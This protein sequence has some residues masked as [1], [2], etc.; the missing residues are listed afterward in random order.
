MV[1][2]VLLILALLWHRPAPSV[3]VL[4]RLSR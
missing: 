2:R 1:T 4:H 3:G